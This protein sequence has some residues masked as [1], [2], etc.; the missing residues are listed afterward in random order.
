MRP[1]S[2]TLTPQSDDDG[3]CASQT[4]AAGGVQ[5]LTIAGALASGGAVIFNYPHRIEITS[6]GDDTSKTFIVTG[7]DAQ[8]LALTESVT[9]AS[10]AAATTT[11]YFK[12]VSSVTVSGN[13][14]G[15]VK[16][17]VLGKATTPWWPTCWMAQEA[18]VGVITE[19]SG[20]INYDVHY[21][22]IPL[23]GV[24][25]HD[26]SPVVTPTAMDDKTAAINSSVS[27]PIT[28][29]RAISNSGTGTLIVHFIQN[30]A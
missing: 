26:I 28:A 8:G 13:T 25:P 18:N 23:N 22:N 16:V 9:G 19:V 3:I 20:T 17:G 12:T 24:S 15:A 11:K 27:V 14:A 21:T 29:I 2:F 1:K 6:A 30:A 7:T 5:S 10:G 4:P